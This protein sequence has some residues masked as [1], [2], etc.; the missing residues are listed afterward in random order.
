MDRRLAAHALA[1]HHS[2][3]GALLE[4]DGS[5]R[6]LADPDLGT[7]DVLHR[8]NRH[9]Q[10]VCDTA[11]EVESVGMFFVRAVAEIEPRNVHPA[12]DQFLKHLRGVGCRS[13]RC[14]DLGLAFHVGRTL[15]H[16]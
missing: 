14:D 2:D 3:L 4:H 5:T 10:V 1:R 8:S 11:N 16:T 12:R 15:G 9:I 6:E 13:K 7:L